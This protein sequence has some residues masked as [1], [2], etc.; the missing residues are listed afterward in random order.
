MSTV[1][2]IR[3]LSVEDEP[4]TVEGTMLQLEYFGHTVWRTATY[5]DAASML[6][7]RRFSLVIVD[8]RLLDARDGHVASGSSLIAALR[9]GDFGPSNI[10]TPFVF[11]TAAAEWVLSSYHDVER[12]P[13]YLG[14]L[15]KGSDIT[16]RLISIVTALAGGEGPVDGAE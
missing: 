14:V 5:D 13:T 3:I 12:L 1:T 15:E 9:R 11:L 8:E 7:K 10:D 16:P 6:A 4:E 2:G